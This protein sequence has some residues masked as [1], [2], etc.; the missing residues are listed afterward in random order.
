MPLF[1]KNYKDMELSKNKKQ[2]TL[3]FDLLKTRYGPFS[4]PEPTGQE[5]VPGTFN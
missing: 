3:F 5:T 2:E 1:L 4:E